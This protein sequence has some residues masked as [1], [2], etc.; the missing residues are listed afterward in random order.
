MNPD[1][2]DPRRERVR[3]E[4]RHPRSADWQSAVSP[5]GSRRGLNRHRQRATRSKANGLRIANPRYSRLPVG[6]TLNT[7][8][9]CFHLV[10]TLMVL[11]ALLPVGTLAQ[12]ARSN[13]VAENQAAMATNQHSLG[14]V[15]S[16]SCREC[17]EKFYTLWSTSFHG[18]A[19][20]P[21]TAELAKTKLTPQTK[22]IVAGQ[23]R[24][25]ADLQ[26]GRGHRAHARPTRRAIPSCRRWAARTSSIF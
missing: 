14:Y 25:R 4:M 15:G 23:Y 22:E 6:A 9:G 11:A 18:L 8:G 19:M 26:N 20:Q 16:A 3:G 12:P 1:C 24:F 10:L 2:I 7:V 5:A 13:P 17:H 21:Y